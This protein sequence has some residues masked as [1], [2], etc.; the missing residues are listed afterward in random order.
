MLLVVQCA[1]LSF[2]GQRDPL[3]SANRLAIFSSS[4]LISTK[5]IMSFTSTI[6]VCKRLGGRN[7]TKARE[8]PSLIVRNNVYIFFRFRTGTDHFGRLPPLFSPA[9]VLLPRLLSDEQLL[10]WLLL[11][12]Q[13]CF[14]FPLS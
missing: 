8:H 4:C 7:I 2:R 11:V 9:C 5:S 14:R 6:I 12:A 3:I 10:L 13:D 1:L